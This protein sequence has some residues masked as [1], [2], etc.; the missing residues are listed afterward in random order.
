VFKIKVIEFDTID[1]DKKEKL[2]DIIKLHYLTKYINDINIGYRRGVKRY[3]ISSLTPDNSRILIKD[4]K[5]EIVCIK[6][7]STCGEYHFQIKL[8]KETER[9]LKESIEKN[10]ALKKILDKLSFNII[11]H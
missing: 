4:G 8:N 9:I 10:I 1:E 7:R 6:N 5:F 2:I 3:T 11:E